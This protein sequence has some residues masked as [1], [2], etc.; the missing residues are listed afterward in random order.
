MSFGSSKECDKDRLSYRLRDDIRHLNTERRSSLSEPDSYR[1]RNLSWCSS[2]V[3]SFTCALVSAKT[4]A[5]NVSRKYA[6]ALRRSTCAEAKIREDEAR[7][8]RV[9]WRQVWSVGCGGE[10]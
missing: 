3:S 4:S 1:S 10:G 6:H 7:R 5:K 2:N 8:G 9:D